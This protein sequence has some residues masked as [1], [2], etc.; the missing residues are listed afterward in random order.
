MRGSSGYGV[1][2]AARCC[3]CW[4]WGCPCSAA[5]AMTCR[6]GSAGA[7][8]SPWLRSKAVRA[9]LRA[10]AAAQPPAA[11]ARTQPAAA[12]APLAPA[13]ARPAAAGTGA[14]TA[15]ASAAGSGAAGT[16]AV[17][18]ERFSFFVTSY[19]AM[20]RLSKSTSGFGGDLRYG[21]ADGLSGADK[22]CT[23]IAES[24]MPG[25]G[26]KGWRAFLSV[27]KGP[28][29]RRSTRSIASATALGTTGAGGCSR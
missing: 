15:G 10:V 27:T 8:A 2:G 18:T 12:Q 13:R 20:Q 14:A 17:P 16:T 23:E 22:I 3:A 19:A 5:A 7:A 24:S 29:V 9:A 6:A 26:A 28:A 25:S 1:T 21:Q 11:A 4:R